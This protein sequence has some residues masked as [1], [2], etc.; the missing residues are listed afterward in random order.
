MSGKQATYSSQ[1]DIDQAMSGPTAWQA[2]QNLSAVSQTALQR[3]SLK[4]AP[5]SPTWHA[6]Q[7]H[8]DLEHV[9][10]CHQPLHSRSERLA[11][12]ATASAS[13][14]IKQSAASPSSSCA[15]AELGTNSESQSDCYACQHRSCPAGAVTATA[16][17]NL[18]QQDCCCDCGYMTKQPGNLKLG[19]SRPASACGF[20]AVAPAAVRPLSADT[21][22]EG[23]PAVLRTFAAGPVRAF[24]SRPSP[25]L[26]SL[27][28]LPVAAATDR[29]LKS[30]LSQ[31]QQS[32]RA[33]LRP[34]SSL[35]A[36]A[37]DTPSKPG[38]PSP[39]GD[40]S[41]GSQQACNCQEGAALLPAALPSAAPAPDMQQVAC[42]KELTL[43]T[44]LSP[45]TSFLQMLDQC[46]QHGAGLPASAQPDIQQQLESLAVTLEDTTANCSTGCQLLR[47]ASTQLQQEQP[48]ARPL[49]P[50]IGKL[51][52][53]LEPVAANT[54]VSSAST[55]AAASWSGAASGGSAAM[56][57]TEDSTP[58]R[59]ADKPMQQNELH[60]LSTG[61]AESRQ[62]MQICRLSTES[63]SQLC[64]DTMCQ[65]LVLS[66]C[67][68][69]PAVPLK[70]RLLKHGTLPALATAD[71][72]AVHKKPSPDASAADGTVHVH[73]PQKAEVKSGSSVQ[74]PLQAG[75]AQAARNSNQGRQLPVSA[76]G[77]RAKQQQQSLHVHP[78][79][80]DASTEAMCTSPEN[81]Q[82]Q[83][84]SKVWTAQQQWFAVRRR[85]DRVEAKWELTE[86]DG[87]D[88]EGSVSTESTL[89][90]SSVGRCR[91]NSGRHAKVCSSISP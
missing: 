78:E 61:V 30:P 80:K 7:A 56:L 85:S 88:S 76:E 73:Q 32:F 16:S 89:R 1:R 46:Q 41:A 11:R 64:N 57:G 43:G 58:V 14:A 62:R 67:P 8:F 3:V 49:G 66:P 74:F 33:Q 70:S 5:L 10:A 18:F 91:V 15:V 44:E 71:T 40:I 50:P 17:A 9:K 47:P 81:D 63:L 53:G 90:P 4:Q 87:S 84:F 72:I 20:R 6:R 59:A 55:F 36:H 2:G 68:V 75:P 21:T 26:C 22:K 28:V 65:P 54:A 83:L 35:A 34:N 79:H 39:P 23:K 60:Q 13:R 31:L 29:R 82:T 19:F 86:S 12:P 69:A 48:G 25:D 24:G 52:G 38:H 77:A 37:E 27:D 45:E 51:P 42:S